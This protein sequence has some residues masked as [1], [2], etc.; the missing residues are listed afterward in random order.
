MDRVPLSAY[1]DVL[2]LSEDGCAFSFYPG[3][4]P[5]P[6]PV[7]FSSLP[8]KVELDFNADIII[9]DSEQLLSDTEEANMEKAFITFMEKNGVMPAFFK[10]PSR[11]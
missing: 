5:V 10:S 2:F 1:S 3:S 4:I 9:N 11:S 6:M 8:H 7:G